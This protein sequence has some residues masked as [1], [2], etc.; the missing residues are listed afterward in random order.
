MLL[1]AIP[2]ASILCDCVGSSLYWLF[3]SNEYFFNNA[4]SF[5]V[6][7]APFTSV[8]ISSTAVFSFCI[9]VYPLPILPCN[10]FIISPS[11]SL[12]FIGNMV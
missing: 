11:S 10:I 12:T 8:A 1:N 3:L 5:E 9:Y 6:L 2:I 4:I 7:L